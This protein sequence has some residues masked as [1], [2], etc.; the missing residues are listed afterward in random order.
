MPSTTTPGVTNIFRPQSSMSRYEK[1]QTSGP[2]TRPSNPGPTQAHL[3]VTRQ[4]LVE[5]V[6]Q[7]VV[8]R[9]DLLHELDVP[10]EPAQVV[11]HQL[12]R[13]HRSHTAG[14][15]RRGMDVATLHE[16]EHFSCRSADVQRLPVE[17]PPAERVQ[18]P[19]DVRDR[20][21]AVLVL[22]RCAGVLGPRQY[23]RVRLGDHLL[24]VVDPDEVL[25]EDVVVEHVFGRF[26]EVDDPLA[27]VR[28]CTP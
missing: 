21:V 16:A 26:T 9:N 28:C 3:L 17:L 18:G 13:G 22:V 4:D 27:E 10:H 25:L 1:L 19:H 6:E 11:G 14:V 2:G 5:E 24:A 20:A 12:H 23:G 7:V 8:H 15:Q